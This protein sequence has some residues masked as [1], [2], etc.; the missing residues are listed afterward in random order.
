MPDEPS[1]AEPALDPDEAQS[2]LDE[3]GQDIDRTR[4]EV[5]DA[6]LTPADQGNDE[7]T[8][9]DSGATPDEDD[10]NAAPA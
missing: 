9:V 1:S 10:Q 4:R 3:L 2:R 6:D 5:D 8:Y 7:D